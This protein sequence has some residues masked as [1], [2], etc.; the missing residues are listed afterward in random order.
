[1]AAVPFLQIIKAAQ[2]SNRA[3]GRKVSNVLSC[4]F[5]RSERK[6]SKSIIVRYFM[7]K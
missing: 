3:S 6:V 4:S 7:Q 5:T 2:E 1:M